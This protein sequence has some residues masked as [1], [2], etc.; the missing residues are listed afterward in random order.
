LISAA[1]LRSRGIFTEA[2]RDVGVWMLLMD[3]SRGGAM[4][5]IADP[6]QPSR[7]HFMGEEFV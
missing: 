4:L 6:W 3:L 7:A 5:R 2:A 1:S